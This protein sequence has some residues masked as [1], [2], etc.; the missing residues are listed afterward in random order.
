VTA[1]PLAGVSVTVK[2]A[3]T[4]PEFPSVTVTSLIESAG[5]ASSS[6]IVPMPWLSVI[7]ALTAF[8]RLSANVSFASSST[9]PLT[10]TATCFA[11]SPAAKLT[12]PV[13]AR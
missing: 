7:D 9:S 12:V 4:V 13:V 11:V 6:V 1:R 8:V 10:I 2:V 5:S 3:A